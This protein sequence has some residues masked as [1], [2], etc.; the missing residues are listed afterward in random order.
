MNAS[1]PILCYDHRDRTAPPELCATCRRMKV[2]ADIVG[3]VVDAMRGAGFALRVNDG[4]SMRPE[5][6]TTDRAAIV[7]ELIETDDDLLEIFEVI[8]PG[9]AKPYRRIGWVR[10]VYGNDGYDVVSDYTTNLEQ[11]LKPINDYADTLA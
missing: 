10:F 5:K 8:P 9:G 4:E 11:L 2:E 3:R 1:A 7:A 6:P